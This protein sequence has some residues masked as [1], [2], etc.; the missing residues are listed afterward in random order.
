MVEFLAKKKGVKRLSFH[1]MLISF[2][3]VVHK[4]HSP[5]SL[6]TP[7][8]EPKSLACVVLPFANF[9]LRSLNPP[10]KRPAP[11]PSVPGGRLQHTGRIME[12][13]PVFPE[14]ILAQSQDA[15]QY[16]RIPDRFLYSIHF[17][18]NQ[19]VSSR[20]SSGLNS[21]RFIL[22]SISHKEI[23]KVRE[24]KGK[25]LFETDP[26]VAAVHNVITVN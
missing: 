11:T 18:R 5:V 13:T 25:T 10:V 3:S 22:R 15:P 4:M 16:V 14:L 2:I 8:D 24:I 17:G 26:D 23:K 21:F 1:I 19:R 7:G 20:Q 6:P 9:I 12:E